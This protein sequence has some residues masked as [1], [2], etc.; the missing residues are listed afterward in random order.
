MNVYKRKISMLTGVIALVVVAFT[1]FLIDSIWYFAIIFS[2]SG[3]FLG[4][5]HGTSMKIMLDYGATRNTGRY[6]TINEIVIGIGFGV[7]PIVA[8]YVVLINMYV[9]FIYIIASGIVFLIILIF[10]SRNI[11]RTKKFSN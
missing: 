9:I 8:G 3:L 4:L 6:S 5:I 2:L 11:K 7:T 10:L 1:I